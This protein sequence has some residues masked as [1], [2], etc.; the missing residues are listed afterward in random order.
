MKA[1][2]AVITASLVSFSGL[3]SAHPGHGAHLGDAAALHPFMGVEHILLMAVVGV[4]AY[5]LRNRLFTS[6]SDDDRE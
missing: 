5:A 1:I 2:Q 3:L 4:G 6:E